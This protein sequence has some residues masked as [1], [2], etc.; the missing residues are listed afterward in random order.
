M[1]NIFSIDI[2]FL[3]EGP[4]FCAH[5]NDDVDDD[6][7]MVMHINNERKNIFFNICIS[8]LFFVYD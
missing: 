3:N 1:L 5:D 4:N 7:D 6:A 2:N 8:R